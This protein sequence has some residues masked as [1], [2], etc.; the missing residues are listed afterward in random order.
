VAE[1]S[2]QI[3]GARIE[4]DS[5]G[6]SREEGKRRRHEGWLVVVLVIVVVA[7]NDNS[8]VRIVR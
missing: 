4:G 3:D 1:S 2:I 7:G 6:K 8:S 5:C